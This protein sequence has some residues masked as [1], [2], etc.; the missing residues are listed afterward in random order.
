METSLIEKAAHIMVTAHGDQKRKTNNTPYILHPMMVAFKLQELGFE[1]KVIAAALVH[2]VLEDTKFTAEQLEKEL[3]KEVL[4]LV[5]PLSEDKSLEWEDRK[6][7]HVESIKNAPAD[8][9][10]VSVTDKIHNLESLIA[11]HAE[12]GPEIWQ[13]FN[14]GKEKKMWFEN[15]LLKMYKSTWSHPLINKYEKLLR[16]AEA[17]D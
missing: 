6:A 2:D 8:A 9:K 11:G 10:A 5:L 13:K 14:R 4:E 3:G 7:K 12:M 1:P 15:E 16:Q 17:L